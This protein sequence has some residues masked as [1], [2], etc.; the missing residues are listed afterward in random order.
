GVAYPRWAPDFYL[1]YG[2]PIFLFTPL[3]PYY[4]VVA[5]HAV[6]LPFPSATNVVEA[7]ALVASGLFAYGWLR[8]YVGPAGA[9]T[10]AV[11]FA[12]APYHL[13]NLFYRGDL[14]EFLAATWFPA[15]LWAL[16]AL[17]A[18]PTV[19]RLLLLALP[20]A[21]LLLTHFISALLFLPA[22]GVL[23]VATINWR[24]ASAVSKSLLFG[25]LAALLAAGLSA[26]SWL[27]AL[28]LSGDATFAKLLRFYSYGENFAGAGQ[29]FS[30]S[31]VQHY[32]AIFAGSQGFGYQFGL[33]QSIALGAGIII[34]LLRLRARAN[35]N[36]WATPLA[37]LLIALASLAG[38]LRVSAPFWAA[39]PPLQLVQFPWRLLAI[40]ALPAAYFCALAIDALAARLQ[41]A[42]GL[43]ASAAIAASCLL[44]LPP[45]RVALP[46][47]FST[48]AG[49]ARFELLYHLAGTSAAAEYLPPWVSRR[50]TTSAEVFSLVIGSAPPADPASAIAAWTPSSRQER[51]S[52]TRSQPGP[53]V[54]PVLAFPGW[55][56]AIDG[57]PVAAH[58]APASGLISVDVAAGSHTVT[59]QFHDPPAARLG[60][61]VSLVALLVALGLCAV[62]WVGS[63]P[64]NNVEADPPVNRWRLARR[65]AL[66]SFPIAAALLLAAFG[67]RAGAPNWQALDA[68]LAGGIHVTGYALISGRQEPAPELRMPAGQPLQLLLR[69]SSNGGRQVEIQLTDAAATDWADWQASLTPGTTTVPLALP[70]ALPPGLYTLRLG[71]APPGDTA[72]FSLRNARLVRLLPVDGTLQLG[73]LVITTAGAPPAKAVAP[74]ADWPGQATIGDVHLPASVRAG[75]AFT[76]IWTWQAPAHPSGARLTEIIHLDDA[77]GHVLAAADTEPA[78]GVY[79][80]PFWLP[81][82]AVLDHPS[83]RLPAD[84]PPGRYMVHLG[85][86]N[87]SQAIPA[88]DAAGHVLGDEAVAGQVTVLPPDQPATW[89]DR[90]VPVGALHVE[91]A[92]PVGQ[93]TAG[94]TVTVAVRW[95]EGTAA[96]GVTAATV[97]LER[98]GQAL[99][100]SA[101]IIGG[102]SYPAARWR[103]GETEVQLFD[104]TVPGGTPPGPADL[105]VAVYNDIAPVQAR[106]TIGTVVVVGRP[107]VYSAQPATPAAVTF[108]DGVQLVGYDLRADGNLLRQGPITTR[109]TLDVTLYWKAPGPLA[110]PL[111]VTLQLLSANNHLLAQA[112]TE[113]G[114]GAAPATG[115]LPGEII[116]SEHHVVLSNVQPGVDHLIVALYNPE[117]AQRILTSDGDAVTLTTVTMP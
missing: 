105:V 76:P 89:D 53:V 43:A 62:G 25:A 17:L 29:L 114:N 77:A 40:A 80:T 61:I 42:G 84:M 6:G 2:Y 37:F 88:Q 12:L 18:A 99:A 56:A 45:P 104:L 74:V 24:R 31:P 92:Q 13:V 19:R 3:L 86:R 22:V 49:I 111:K 101:A 7:M 14:A 112:D 26:V 36:G 75:T 67:G 41:S 35:V 59:L 109:T 4:L 38:C 117:T 95:Y 69:G 116:T 27:P 71:S 98:N 78:S 94:Q 93:V 47:D 8:R 28:T 30:R 32:T 108:A 115:W 100:S 55:Q 102:T 63:R 68:D 103:A 21:G 113:P 70:P 73:P 34:W 106:A 23:A 15:I 11:L 52:V 48:A 81:N 107:H 51:F 5:V 110:S 44:L 60:D 33:L 46:A 85:L 82:E 79:P 65:A 10:G 83:V 50:Q 96:A 90:G 58:P 87:G 54:L 97:M 91:L 64:R 66:V 16:D 1:G 72:D 9:A 20:V 57:R 39:L